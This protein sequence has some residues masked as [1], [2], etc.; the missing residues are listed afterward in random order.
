VAVRTGT[1]LRTTDMPAA[2]TAVDTAITTP[3]E[4]N[5]DAAITAVATVETNA[6][7]SRGLN[8][9]SLGGDRTPDV[10]HLAREI[11]REL[12]HV[13]ATMVRNGTTAERA[14]ALS[15]IKRRFPGAWGTFKNA[16]TST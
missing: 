8:W 10:Q 6:H 11:G 7:D 1:Q 12:L 15:R 14:K 9:T 5:I 16:T 4:A 3:T 2:G 13:K